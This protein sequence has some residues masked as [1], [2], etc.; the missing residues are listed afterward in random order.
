M[1]I[2]IAF[3]VDDKFLQGLRVAI[4]SIQK[5]ASTNDF[6]R[7]HIIHDK[8]S[9]SKESIE[10]VSKDIKKGNKVFFYT[11]GEEY[12]EMPTG[13]AGSKAAAYRFAFPGLIPDSDK[14]LY[15]DSDLIILKDIAPLFKIDLGLNYVGGADDIGYRYSRQ[16]N[17]QKFFCKGTYINSGVLLMNLKLM[18]ED[19]IEKKLI[20]TILREQHR[21]TYC[22][23]DVINMVCAGR[24]LILPHKWN[25]KSIS[26]SNH[27]PVIINPKR[28]EILKAAKDPSIL[29]YIT[30]DKP[31]NSADCPHGQKWRQLYLE[32]TAEEADNTFSKQIRRLS[33]LNKLCVFFRTWDLRKRYIPDIKIILTRIWLRL[34]KK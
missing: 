16:M 8:E 24:I 34:I 29:H 4:Y 12:A 28:E 20:S 13:T 1:R 9:F 31:W 11:A 27:Y 3:A 15:L 26:K 14:I 10:T 22:D 30:N 21:I 17:P 5:N 6:Y 7:F 19:N 32:M 23:Q 2:D 18:R 33:M 25:T